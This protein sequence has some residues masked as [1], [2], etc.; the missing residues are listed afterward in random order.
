MKYLTTNEIRY[1][2]ID[3]NSTCNLRCPQCARNHEGETHPELPLLEL[4][5]D[6]YKKFLS[7]TPNIETVMWCGNYG[8]VIV[9]NT[10]F[11]CLKYVVENTRAKLIITT[12][13]SA[14]DEDWWREVAQLL[15]GRGK[16]N[17]SIDGLED[18]NHI[19]RVNAN[20]DKI[21]KNA[22]AFIDAGGNA[23]WDYL[24]FGHNEH[25]VDDAVNIA[26]TM[27]FNQFQIKLTNRFVNDEQYKNNRQADENQNVKTRRSEYILGMPKNENYQGTGKTQNEEIIEKY[28]SWNNYVNTTPINCKW[29]PNGQIFLDFE[30]RIWPCTW[31][32][33]GYHHYGDNTQKHQAQKLFQKYG[34][35]FN[36]LKH[37]SLPEIL[38][39]DYFG[40]QFCDSWQGTIDDEVPKLFACGRTCGTDYEFSSAYG[41]N[42]R[43]IE[44]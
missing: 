24:V 34:N 28:G 39:N 44:L 4:S 40:K 5:R 41:S 6:A 8:E 16:V 30:E 19:Y 23:R 2:Q 33:S 3:H 31:T 7:V 18:T 13:A 25:Q 27:G 21:I 42:K 38:N 9:S 11:D 32:A 22:Q 37:Y 26:K 14:R 10:F 35:N 17:F 12:N 43:L 15:K 1:L 20:W 29:K 36:S